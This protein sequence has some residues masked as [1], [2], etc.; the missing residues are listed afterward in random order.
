MSRS[1]PVYAANS[2]GPAGGIGA[3]AEASVREYGELS[4]SNLLGIF[5]ELEGID[6][7]R[8][9]AKREDARLR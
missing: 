7:V 8:S 9:S 1:V 5:G 6:L 3:L 4:G 2:A